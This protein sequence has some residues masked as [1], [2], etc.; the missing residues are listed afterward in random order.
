[1]SVNRIDK[2]GGLD[3]PTQVDK[4]DAALATGGARGASRGDRVELSHDGRLRASLARR[5]LGLP[6]LR[7]GRIDELRRAIAD[8]SYRVNSRAVARAMVELEDDLGR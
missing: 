4:P 7:E 6:E 3:R 1:M 5:A 8:G 2:T